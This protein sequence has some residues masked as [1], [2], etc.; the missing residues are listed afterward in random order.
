M[1]RCYYWD[2]IEPP[3]A[4]HGFDAVVAATAQS[5]WLIVG[6]LA[7]MR[8]GV[9]VTAAAVVAVEPIAHCC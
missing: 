2:Q 7:L 9:T 3:V 8:A 1:D 5:Y 4:G 6:Q